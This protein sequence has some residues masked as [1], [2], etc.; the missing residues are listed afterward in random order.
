MASLPDSHVY[1]Y[2]C[3]T[4]LAV[5]NPMELCVLFRQACNR[6]GE[7]I[8]INKMMQHESEAIGTAL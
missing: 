4:V 2:L 1:T 6:K 8:V 5:G 7:T 3:L